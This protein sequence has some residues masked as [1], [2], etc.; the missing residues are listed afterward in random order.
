MK[1]NHLNYVILSDGHHCYLFE[2][3]GKDM[4]F[5][6]Y[7]R[8]LALVVSESDIDLLEKVRTNKSVSWGSRIPPLSEI[9]KKPYEVM[10]NE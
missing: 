4:P 6:A 5:E 2:R 1:H 10:F 9:E 3:L 7:N 8:D